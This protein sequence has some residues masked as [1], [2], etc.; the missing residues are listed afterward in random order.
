MSISR[1]HFISMPFLQLGSVKQSKLDVSEGCDLWSPIFVFVW[2]CRPLLVAGDLLFSVNLCRHQRCNSLILQDSGIT[3][4][5]KLTCEGQC[6]LIL[7][8]VWAAKVMHWSRCVRGGHDRYGWYFRGCGELW[9]CTQTHQKLLCCSGSV[10][11]LSNL[12]WA[13]PGWASVWTQLLPSL[14]WKEKHNRITFIVDYFRIQVESLKNNFVLSVLSTREACTSRA[15]IW[16]AWLSFVWAV[17]LQRRTTQAAIQQPRY[18]NN[19]ELL[20]HLTS[21]VHPFALFLNVQFMFICKTTHRY[22]RFVEFRTNMWIKVIFNI[23]SKECLSLFKCYW[24]QFPLY[25][26]SWNLET[27]KKVFFLG[28]AYI[29]WAHQLE[30]HVYVNDGSFGL[31]I[32]QIGYGICYVNPVFSV[33]PLWFQS[34]FC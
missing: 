25:F 9:W 8:A 7:H 33:L 13:K 32:V 28:C 10:A 6:H 14:T 23:F 18:E 11:G 31:I 12:I 21:L 19:V 20:L 34:K 5:Y 29:I 22:Q 27:H 4:L 26:L 24:L 1:D 30:S 3:L 15:P 16:E 17:D 2:R